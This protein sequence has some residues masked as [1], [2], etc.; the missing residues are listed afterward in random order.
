M[1]ITASTGSKPNIRLA[2]LS[3]F[4]VIGASA[5]VYLS[6]HYYDLRFGTAGFK[7][8]C[9]ISEAMNCD[10]VTSS[11]FAEITP[12]LPLASFVAGW[13][14]ALLILSLLARIADW[15]REAVL[16]STL[17]NG[18]A[19]LYSIALL[20]VMFVVIHKFCLFCLVIDAINF[21]LFA[22]CLS[23]LSGYR[24]DSVFGG[25][26]WSKIQTNVLI[27]I[28]TVFVVVVVL[29]PSAENSAATGS[30]EIQT[31]VNTI[32]QSTPVVITTP[33]GASIIG[34]PNAAITIHEFSDFQCPYC[35]RGAVLMN[36][37][38]SRYEGKVRVVFMPFPLDMACNRLITH[39][40][41]AYSC[42]LA[43]SSFCA[44]KEGKF[45][46]VYEKIFE[47]QELL[48]GDSAVKIP[49]GEGIKADSLKTCMDSEDAKK[50]VSLSIEEG[51]KLK[52]EATPTFFING[53]KVDV[54]L[55]LEAWDKLIAG[56]K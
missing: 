9:N 8:L 49:T 56:A 7:S 20:T 43:R 25:A 24:S 12:G 34:N 26:R 37:I 11:R 18:F 21:A 14:V 16:V 30:A 28:G 33:P 29:R 22:L 35:K 27:T 6:K 4:S 53:K 36:Q 41:H 46:P 15:R 32:L 39:A 2:L 19:S 45:Q 5:A 3:L 50:F 55:P 54:S 17:M 13:F 51:L 38:V 40:M 10:A 47:D 23:I 44:S 1:S 31:A 52:V 42:E 48:T